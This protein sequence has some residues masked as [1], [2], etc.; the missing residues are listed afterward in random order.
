[1]SRGGITRS[2]HW[3]TSAVLDTG[4]PCDETSKLIQI[5]FDFEKKHSRR[6]WTGTAVRGW[7]VVVLLLKK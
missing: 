2:I 3:T 7:F 1:M 6:R 4:D 5:K